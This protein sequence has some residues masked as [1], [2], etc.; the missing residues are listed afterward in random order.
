MFS[1]TTTSD[2]ALDALTL[3]VAQLELDISA[4]QAVTTALTTSVTSNTSA[5][6]TNAS[7]IAAN[8]SAL[9]NVVKQA[10][11]EIRFDGT[12]YYFQRKSSNCLSIFRLD[13]GFLEV[14]L[15]TPANGGPDITDNAVAVASA[16][17]ANNTTARTCFAQ[18][19]MAP[20]NT[21]QQKVQISILYSANT[22]SDLVPYIG[23]VSVHV[24]WGT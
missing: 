5:I 11:C 4:Q 19:I 12:D 15:D 14:T 20:V 18:S 7:N 8:T 22:A 13:A 6:A 3:R 16:Y 17:G 10:Y 2:E 21:S 23:Y 9:A 1:V 24:N